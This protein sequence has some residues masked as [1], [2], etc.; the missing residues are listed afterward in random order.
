M[1]NE[2]SFLIEKKNAIRHKHQDEIDKFNEEL[3]EIPLRKIMALNP[4]ERL[5][6]FNL[7]FTTPLYKIVDKFENNQHIRIRYYNN[8][9]LTPI[10]TNDNIQMTPLN[11]IISDLPLYQPFYPETFYGTYDFL[12]RTGH[13]ILSNPKVHHSV[14]LPK[15]SKQSKQQILHIGREHTF[16]SAEAIML[17]LERN[18]A[19]YQ[20]NTYQV[21]LSGSESFSKVTYDF[22]VG[23]PR[24]NYLGQAYKFSFVR[25]TRDLTTYDFVSIDAN[26]LLETI[27]E[28]SNEELDLHSNIFYLLTIIPF[29]SKTSKIIIRLNMLGKTAWNIL[30][31]IVSDYFSEYEFY[32]P[33][34]SNQLN[35]EIY[36]YATKLKSKKLAI[37]TY[38]VILQNLYHHRLHELL[39]LNRSDG[40]ISN[41]LNKMF[42]THTDKWVGGISKFIDELKAETSVKNI[43]TDW[44]KNA[45]LASVADLK[46]NPIVPHTKIISLELR[47]MFESKY[48]IKPRA[49]DLLYA[50]SFYQKFLS[51]RADLNFYKRIMDTK[52]SRIF[53]EMKKRPNNKYSKLLVWEELCNKIDLYQE[54][55]PTLKEKHN[56]ELLTNAWIK[57]FEILND[58][59][60]LLLRGDN[61]HVANLKTFHLCEAPGA[62]ISATNYF[63]AGKDIEWRW[64]AQTLIKGESGE[65]PIIDYFDLIKKHP[66]N[67]IF[68]D[69]TDNSG[70]IT[71]SRV[72]KS[73]AKNKLLSNID[74]I[75]ADGGINISPNEL[76]EQEA[77]L[78]KLVMGQIVCILACLSEGKNAIVKIFLPVSEPLTLSMIYL[79]VHVFR[80]V[81]FVKPNGSH[82][83]NSEIY[84]VL[85]DYKR[86]SKSD[87]NILYGLLDDPMITSKSV[88][89]ETFDKKFI[90]TY[91][92]ASEKLIQRQISALQRNYYYYYHFDE[93]KEI[94][95]L[96]RS[97]T[98]MW[99][100]KNVLNEP[101]QFLTN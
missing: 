27:F 35:S 45:Q 44:L 97:Y 98:D 67:W 88:L 10:A 24:N 6:P 95:P 57:L 70:N 14:T 48:K 33:K 60:T 64:Y 47:P 56:I 29:L 73:Y 69:D 87:L 77:K 30:L 91:A 41:S 50:E 101:K 59:P 40:N 3:K 19:N 74:F 23:S 43:T 93:I 2:D 89:F 51:E 25:S 18:Q 11:K 21:W 38:E 92:L 55:R 80:S 76:N 86:I 15:Q 1:S 78:A 52:P 62:F 53:N 58:D 71:H 36:L 20:D 96:V 90:N 37:T 8:M 85:K 72:I 39:A 22:V 4:L 17:Y 28:W 100:E 84:V 16:G 12:S 26:H 32:R 75:T 9:L 42:E 68:G 61:N 49:P 66:E 54:L 99:L 81:S 13:L 31:D 5:V 82:D 79:L 94:R 7:W 65:N 83:C 34:T 63:L 46:L